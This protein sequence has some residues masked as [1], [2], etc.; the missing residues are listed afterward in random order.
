MYAVYVATE[1]SGVYEQL[2]AAYKF[3]FQ[4]QAAESIAQIMLDIP[5]ARFPLNSLLIPMPTAPSRVRNRGFDHTKLI[6]KIWLR[7][8]N[9]TVKKQIQ[10]L[11]ALKRTSN[12]R[13]VGSTREERIQQ[14]RSE[15]F[16][17]DPSTVIGR[18]CIVLDDVTTT[19][20][21]LAAAAKAL[22][23]AGAARVYGIVFAQKI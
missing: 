4:R 23:S 9:P 13:Q 21:S 3:R 14:V 15:F 7:R 2:L 17:D 18:S 16:V 1:Y 11:C 19:G 12:N 22:K 20:A 6:A 8:L 10:V 5:S